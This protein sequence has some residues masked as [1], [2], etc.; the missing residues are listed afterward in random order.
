MSD[1]IIFVRTVKSLKNAVEFYEAALKPIGFA[2]FYKRSDGTSVWLSEASSRVFSMLWL[3]EKGATAYSTLDCKHVK[4]LPRGILYE[5]IGVDVDDMLERGIF[6]DLRRSKRLHTPTKNEH[7]TYCVDDRT[8]VDGFYLAA[9]YVALYLDHLPYLLTI[10]TRKILKQVCWW[11][12]HLAT[13]PSP[14]QRLV[15]LRH[16]YGRSRRKYY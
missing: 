6:F 11:K 3:V 4:S 15:G 1:A 2:P 5:L 16:N 9:M 13:Q 14:R 7:I 10:M 12:V 8:K